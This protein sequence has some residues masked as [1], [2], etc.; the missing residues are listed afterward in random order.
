MFIVMKLTTIFFNINEKKTCP[1][2]CLNENMH[3]IM[4]NIRDNTHCDVCLNENMHTIMCNIRDNTHCDCNTSQSYCIKLCYL[5]YNVAF[6]LEMLLRYYLN[7]NLSPTV[8]RAKQKNVS[9]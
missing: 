3:T 6:S 2:V 8:A 1:Y 5:I 7:I 9:V 4:C